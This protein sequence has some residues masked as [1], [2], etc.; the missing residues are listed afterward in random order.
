MDVRVAVTINAPT[1]AV[2]PVIAD[3]EGSQETIA[4]ID[5]IEIL[6]RP[7]YG[8]LG[9]KWK[10][11]RTMGGKQAVETMWITEA[12]EESYYVTEARSHGSIYRTRID[13]AESAGMTTLSMDFSA[14]PETFVAKLFTIVLGPLMK[15]SIRNALQQDLEDVKAAVESR[16]SREPGR[17]ATDSP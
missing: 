8:I 11:T 6:E 7:S 5:E 3:I 15:R 10:E 4:G 12:E 9:L 17:M 13:L 14:E 1:G 2:W 16:R